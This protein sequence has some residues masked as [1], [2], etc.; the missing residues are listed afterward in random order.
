MKNIDISELNEKGF[1]HLKNNLEAGQISKLINSLEHSFT[2]HREIQ[3][4]NNV[5]ITTKGVALHV[6]L[7][8]SIFIK[9][10]ETLSESGIYSALKDQYFGSNFILNSFGGNNNLPNAPHYA[11]N[12]HRDI[13]FFSGDLRIM[14]NMIVML[15]D[16]SVENGATFLLPYSHKIPEIPEIAIFYKNAVQMVGKAGD[17]VLFNSNLWHAGGINKTEGHRRALTLTFSKPFMKQQV[18]YCKAIGFDNVEKFNDD[19]RQILGY[20]SRVPSSLDEWY[21]PL[22]KRFYKKN[23]D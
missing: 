13:R 4:K 15:D 10:L 1:V 22:D 3:I 20:N 12:I 14:L 17:I 6:I 18:D 16:F 21:Q 7:N 2:A 19:V 9:F 8:D 5:E 23:Q 11:T